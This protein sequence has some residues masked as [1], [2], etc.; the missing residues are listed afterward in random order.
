MRV[1]VTGRAGFLGSHLASALAARGDVVTSLDIASGSPLI[2]ADAVT[3]VRCDVGS[4][5]ETSQALRAAHPDVIYHT[6]GILSAHAEERPHAAYR[7]NA[8]G[9]YNILQCAGVLDIP[10]VVFT[11]TVATYG[12]GVG[13]TVDEMTPQRPTTMY[14]VTKAFGEILGE[15]FSGRFGLDFRALRLPAVI[16]AGRGPGG[17]SAYASLVV[18]ET[19]RGRRY[20]VPVEESTVMPLI[21]VKDAVA[22]LMAVAAADGSRLRRHTYGIDGF[23]PTA[24]ELADAIA[25]AIPE[26][27][28]PFQPQAETSAIVNTWPRYVD[29]SQA[30][31]DWDWAPAYDLDAAVED[32]VAELAT[33]PDWP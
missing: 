8:T 16:G 2:D 14:G 23:S 33:H 27:H 11:S 26:A 15:Y 10:R 29:G 6:A 18:S 31:A 9:T 12:P 3:M 20:T 1:V 24:R 30:A 13:P 4:W 19:A 32:F 7:A 25:R 22:A 5:A 21:Y 28:I 17:V